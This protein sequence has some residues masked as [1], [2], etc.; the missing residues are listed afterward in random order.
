MEELKP[1]ERIKQ[2]KEDYFAQLQ[3]PRTVNGSWPELDSWAIIKYLDEQAEQRSKHGELKPCPFCGYKPILKPFNGLG[4]GKNP[5]VDE[6]CYC[7]NPNGCVLDNLGCSKTAWNHRA[8][9]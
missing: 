5:L 3:S 4:W 2:I 9:E 8:K 6:W 7:S 1:S